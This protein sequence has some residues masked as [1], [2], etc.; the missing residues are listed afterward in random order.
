MPRLRRY[1]TGDGYYIKD[2]LYGTGHCTWQIAERGLCYL[3]ARGVSQDGDHVTGADRNRLLELKLIWRTGTGGRGPGSADAPALPP[4]V[5]ALA[6]GLRAWANAGGVPALTALLHARSGDHRDR[7]F[8]LGFLGWLSKLDPGITLADLDR[9]SALDFDDIAC[10][11]LQR[12][13]APLHQ[14]FAAQ[15]DTHVLWQLA[16]VVGLVARQ[17][18]G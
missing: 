9:L 13:V 17:R 7:C 5:A 11:A 3:R 8:S 12:L 1:I 4:E 18:R 16:R 10:P 6:V 2:Y 14:H 15:G